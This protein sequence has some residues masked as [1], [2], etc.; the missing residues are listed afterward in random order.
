MSCWLLPFPEMANSALPQP[1]SQRPAKLAVPRYQ[2]A[3]SHINLFLLTCPGMSSWKVRVSLAVPAASRTEVASKTTTCRALILHGVAHPHSSGTAIIASQCVGLLASER[4]VVLCA[5]GFLLP[6]RSAS[7][8][9]VGSCCAWRSP[10]VRA[11]MPCWSPWGAARSLPWTPQGSWPGGCAGRCCWCAGRPQL[12]ACRPGSSAA[13]THRIV[14]YS[15]SQQ[16]AG[17]KL[18]LT[19]LSVTERFNQ[20]H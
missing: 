3:L 8:A 11:W 14:I 15:I 12:S 4:P 16:Q 2:R 6:L 1:K 5:S 10:G 18:R 19:V 13:A 7:E 17:A 9:G 20:M